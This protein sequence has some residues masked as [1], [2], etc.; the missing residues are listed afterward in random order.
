MIS[1]VIATYNRYNDLLRAIDSVSKQTKYPMEIVVVDDCSEELVTEEVF[2]SVPKEIKR[3]LIN[4]P[5]NSGV[6]V[7][8]NIGVNAS[9]GEYISF[10]DDD[11]IFLPNKIAML[12]DLILNSHHKPDLIYHP[13]RILM[14]KEATSYVTQPKDISSS[15]LL[16]RDYLTTNLVGGTP[17][18]TVKRER[19]LAHNGFDVTFPALEDYELWIR[20]LAAEIKVDF[21]SQAL[22]ECHYVTQR[23]SISK[24]IENDIRAVKMLEEKHRALYS[25]LSGSEYKCCQAWHQRRCVQKSLLNGSRRLALKFASKLFLLKPSFKSLLYM[26]SILLGHRFTL[27]LRGKFSF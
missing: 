14:V 25:M 7:C 27:F 6:S 16:P 23:S 24:S 22:T 5:E 12:E 3:V 17:L 15:R 10:L 20:L 19:F 4:N 13:A 9:S 2:S 11:D 1:V 8:R 26:I 21:I 18:V